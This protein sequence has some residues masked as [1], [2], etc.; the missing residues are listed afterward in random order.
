MAGAKKLFIAEGS[1]PK[2]RKSRK[3]NSLKIGQ[4]SDSTSK[5]NPNTGQTMNLLE[6]QDWALCDK[7][8]GWCGQCAESASY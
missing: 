3:R 4:G 6:D 8:C 7:D 5:V 1:K 2:K